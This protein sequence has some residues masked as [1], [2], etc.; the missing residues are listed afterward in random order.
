MSQIIAGFLCAVGFSL[1]LFLLGHYLPQI[2]QWFRPT[3]NCDGDPKFETG[4]VVRYWALDQLPNRVEG[5][6]KL[7]NLRLWLVPQVKTLGSAIMLGLR[8]RP[9]VPAHVL[10]WYLLHPD[11]MPVEMYGRT[12]IF[13]TVYR[14]TEHQACVFGLSCARERHGAPRL[15]KFLLSEEWGDNIYIAVDASDLVE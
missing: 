10:Y 2:S 14:D 1:G 7:S 8:A 6:Y 9:V 11:T 5:E 3:V 13:P 4:L 15:K 12:V